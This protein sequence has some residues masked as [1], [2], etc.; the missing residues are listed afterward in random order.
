[1][2]IEQLSKNCYRV[3]KK[4][5]NVTYAVTFDHKPTKSE[6]ELAI[7]EKLQDSIGGAKGTFGMFATEYIE[8]RRNVVSP[9]TIRTYYIKTRQLSDNFKNKKI[10]NL[11]TADVQAEINLFAKT[12]EPKTAKTLYGFIKSVIA[13]YRPNLVL[14]VKLPQA[15]KKE[16][17][18]P[19]NEDIRRILDHASKTNYSIPFQLGVLSCRRGEICAATIDDLDG[20]NLYIHRSMVENENNEWVIKETPKTEESNRILPLPPTLAEQI[21]KQGFIYD[22]HPNALNKAIHR[23]QKKLG[24]PAF[25]FHALRSYFASY[26][27]SMGIPDSDIMKIGGWKTDNVMKSVYRKSIEESKRE[28][29]EKIFGGLWG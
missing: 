25:K 9:A 8:N 20:N 4:V 21:R 16:V 17:Y 11:T 27:H 5:N 7:A 2:K 22:N 24:I 3:R 14:R 29:I 18:E 23:Y 12:H 6:I 15:I 13:E 10:E 28:S 26:A 1:M 19:T